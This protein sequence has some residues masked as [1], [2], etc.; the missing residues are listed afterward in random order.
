MPRRSIRK[1]VISSVTR[2]S[3]ARP[4]FNSSFYRSHRRETY[5]KWAASVPV[6]F[7]FSVKLPREISHTLRLRAAAKPLANFLGEIEG[8]GARIGVVLIQLPPS[9]AFDRR[10]VRA[11]L[12]TLRS[13]FDGAAVVEPRHRSW[14]ESPVED[15]LR[16]FEIG[17]VGSDPALCDAASIP[18]AASRVAY[19]RLH[20]SPRMYYSKYE[21]SYL[22][23][24]AASI[25]TSRKAATG[26]WCIFDNTAHGF[27]IAN[28]LQLAQLIGAD[29]RRG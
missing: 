10:V 8:L 14:F 16:E 18:I 26:R 5:A 22:E 23:R 7:R 3:S 4:K 21:A 29:D 17:R 24:L 27:A 9:F 1:A 20:G 11:F 12:E 28:A 15:V 19:W 2:A 13:R 25:V 6:D